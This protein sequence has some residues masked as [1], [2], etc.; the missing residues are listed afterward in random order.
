MVCPE[1]GQPVDPSP[2]DPRRQSIGLFAGI[3]AQF[4]RIVGRIGPRE[5]CHHRI[6]REKSE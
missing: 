1:C 6:V 5:H 2:F 3:A 4:R